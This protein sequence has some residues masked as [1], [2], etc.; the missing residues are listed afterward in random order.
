MRAMTMKERLEGGKERGSEGTAGRSGH[1]CSKWPPKPEGNL[2]FLFVLA[3]CARV[4]ASAG[5][6]GSHEYDTVNR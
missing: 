6:V 2:V 1:E 5:I 3:S 4:R